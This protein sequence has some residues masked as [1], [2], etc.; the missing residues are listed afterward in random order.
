MTADSQ[1][2]PTDRAAE[3]LGRGPGV[4]SGRHG[5]GL[6]GA[7]RKTLLR[8]MGPFTHYQREL[9]AEIMAALGRQ[10][11]ELEHLSERHTEQIERLEEIARELIRTAESLR[12]ASD[13]A[14]RDAARAT[15]LAERAIEPGSPYGGKALK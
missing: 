3:L 10:Q 13:D 12:R 15:A 4:Q 8:A 6:R 5:R 14:A 7:V 11:A 2:T 9:D 1:I